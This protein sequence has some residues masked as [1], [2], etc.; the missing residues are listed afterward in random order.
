MIRKML[1][2]LAIISTVASRAQAGGSRDHEAGFFLR[3]STGVGGAKTERAEPAP[4]IEVSGPTGDLNIALGG[5]ITRN[6]ALHATFFGWRAS[7][8]TVNELDTGLNDA[9]LA[10]GAVGLGITYYFMPINLYV[11]PS[12]GP[13]YLV[14]DLTNDS[15][16]TGLGL[17]I[18]FTV[19]KEWW[20][21]DRWAL[22]VAGG[23]GAH[24]ISDDDAPPNWQGASFAV[25]FTS[26]FN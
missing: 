11:S 18:D 10:L 25:R 2:I 13:A 22:G 24:V 5:T 14:T 12:I 15:E 21:S 1:V 3:L 7:D 19:G 23:F 17:G 9:T 4:G 16:A 26:T 8:P 20:V 6:L